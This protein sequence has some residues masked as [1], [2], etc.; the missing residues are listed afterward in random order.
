MTCA[1]VCPTYAPGPPAKTHDDLCP[2]TPTLGGVQVQVGMEP[3]RTTSPV[4]PSGYRWMGHQPPPP[5][6]PERL[7]G[8]P[9]P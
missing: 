6:L 9:D 2:C 1:Q 5:S 3:S 4:S 8:T 7:L